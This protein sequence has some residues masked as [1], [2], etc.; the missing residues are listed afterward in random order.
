MTDHTSL[1]SD[2][3]L[4]LSKDTLTE[5]DILDFPMFDI[6]SCESP[7]PQLP[8]DPRILDATVTPPN[9]PNTFVLYGSIKKKKTQYSLKQS[10]EKQK[11]SEEAAQKY[12]ITRNPRF[13]Y[14]FN[15]T[16]KEEVNQWRNFSGTQKDKNLLLKKLL[17]NI[18]DYQY[19]Y[20]LS[21]LSSKN[22]KTIIRKINL[23]LAAVENEITT[24]Q[25]QITNLS[26]PT[27]A[28]L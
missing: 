28:S 16:L 11:R 3:E 22:E 5:K 2:L 26:Q 27:S 1:S 23:R 21:L 25:N 24:L 10:L 18:R 8:L 14:N 13:H 15:Y 6:T 9:N 19:P 12:S 4:L 20:G 17:L 7:I